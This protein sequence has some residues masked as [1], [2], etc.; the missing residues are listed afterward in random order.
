VCGKSG[1][2][3]KVR[4]DLGSSTAL[5]GHVTVAFRS[6]RTMPPSVLMA[7]TCSW[8]EDTIVIS[9]PGTRDKSAEN[10]EPIAPPPMTNTR[11]GR[12]RDAC[13]GGVYMPRAAMAARTFSTCEDGT[14]K[15]CLREGNSLRNSR[16]SERDGGEGVVPGLATQERYT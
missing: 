12:G 5:T 3:S 6:F 4:G 14:R 13:L 1:E 15:E 2:V 10:S 8:Y 11:F 7:L 9:V 16:E